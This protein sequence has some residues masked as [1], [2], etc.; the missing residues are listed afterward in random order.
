MDYRD[1]PVSDTLSNIFSSEVWTRQSYVLSRGLSHMAEGWKAGMNENLA[2]PDEGAMKVVTSATV[3][4][5][6]SAAMKTPGWVGSLTRGAGIAAA[7]IFV[8]EGSAPLYRAVL[9]ASSSDNL[10]KLNQAGRLLGI[11]LGRFAFEMALTA[12]A[13]AA[14]SIAGIKSYTRVRETMLSTF[15]GKQE[16]IATQVTNPTPSLGNADF[17]FV[18]VKE[19]NVDKVHFDMGVELTLNNLG[20]GKLN[21]DHHGRGSTHKDLS[22]AQQALALPAELLPKDGSTIAFKALDTDSATALAV[23]SNRQSGR[24]VDP[25]LVKMIGE[26][27]RGYVIEP[28]TEYELRIDAVDQLVS[29]IK[30]TTQTKAQSNLNQGVRNTVGNIQSILD[31]TLPQEKII[32]LADTRG[33]IKKIG[34]WRFAKDASVKEVVPGKLVQVVYDN[35]VGLMQGQRIAPVVVLFNNRAN[36]ITIAGRPDAPESKFLVLA[37]N[38][39]ESIESG[40]QGRDNVFGNYSRMSVD[41]V[42]SLVAEFVKPSI[43]N[44]LRWQ[45]ED[46]LVAARKIGTGRATTN[47]HLGRA[48]SVVSL[49]DCG[50]FDQSVDSRACRWHSFR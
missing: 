6:Y 44:K 13:A 12:P 42:S 18:R 20:P 26:R 11:Q 3:A 15:P 37:K 30:R 9:A 4:A 25:A 33:S 16:S 19:N 45:I 29:D 43:A 8:L 1:Q 28:S 24:H 10:Q 46:S 49:V 7:G 22:S 36:R 50:I 5:V 41:K 23:L 17:N 14:G 21:L 32:H 38:K 27:D 40:W 34:E 47:L 39:L 31:N 2:H 35:P 48:I